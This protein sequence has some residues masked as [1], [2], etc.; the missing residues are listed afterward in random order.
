MAEKV[1][2]GLREVRALQPGQTIYDAA[3][4]G[5][6]ARRQ[7]DSVQYVLRYRTAEGR[8]RWFT[9]GRHGAPWTPD[10]ARDEARRRLG[11]IVT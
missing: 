6:G 9:I 5:F 7:K 4:P 10:S 1:K 11:E 8:Q 3:V 2:I